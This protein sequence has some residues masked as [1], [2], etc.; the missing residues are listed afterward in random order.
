MAS[1]PPGDSEWGASLWSDLFDSYMKKGGSKTWLQ[2]ACLD[3]QLQLLVNQP[4]SSSRKIICLVH[5]AAAIVF[6]KEDH[7]PVASQVGTLVFQ[8]LGN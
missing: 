3:P 4:L 6:I 5:V 8:S 2:A 7:L 1:L